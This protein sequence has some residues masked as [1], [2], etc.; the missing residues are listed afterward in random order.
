MCGWVDNAALPNRYITR[1]HRCLAH[2]HVTPETKTKTPPRYARSRQVPGKPRTCCR[3]CC[4]K[5]RAR[6]DGGVRVCKGEDEEKDRYNIR[7]CQ[8][9]RRESVER[10]NITYRKSML[11][12]TRVYQKDRCNKR[13]GHCIKRIISLQIFE[14]N[15]CN[16]CRHCASMIDQLR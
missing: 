9:T 7:H 4:N 11:A 13:L 15:L 3:Y 6:V 12:L 16:R 1:Q 5:G 8:G 10:F 2:L 14:L